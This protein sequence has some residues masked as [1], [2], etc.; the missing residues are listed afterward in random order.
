[1]SNTQPGLHTTGGLL[2]IQA[3]EIAWAAGTV[4]DRLFH[5]GMELG[6]NQGF[7]R[8]A[9]LRVLLIEDDPMVGKSLAQA[10]RAQGMSVDWIKN[11]LEGEHALAVGGYALVLLD[12]GLSGKDGLEVLKSARA[13]RSRIPVL[14]IT[15]RDAV[16]DR[17]AGLDLGADDYITKPFDARELF[18]RMRA[19]LRRHGG[20]AQSLVES[21]EVTL[22]LAIHELSY[23]GHRVTLS[24]REFAL[25]RALM[26]PPGKIV[27]RHELEERLYGWGEEVDSNAV[28]VLIH[29]IRKKFDKDIIRNVRGA[30]WMVIKAGQ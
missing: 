23:R 10:L 14:I 12:L 16:D 1:M 8:E 26:D 24:P 29:S 9:T 18:A 20:F 21:G 3:H 25:M 15:A 7:R 2:K 30:G 17:V 6:A 28:E 27:A 4:S 19:V 5:G 11:G 13:V 22:D